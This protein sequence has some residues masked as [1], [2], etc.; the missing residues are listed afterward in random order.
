MVFSAP[1]AVV[2][3]DAEGCV[4]MLNP[5]AERLLQTSLGE[6]AGRSYAEVFGPSLADRVL[7]LFLRTVR[8]GEAIEPLLLK[9]MLPGGRG[10]EL[11]ASMGPVRD[12]TG[13]LAGLLFVADEV[14]AAPSRAQEETTLRLREALRRYLGENIAAM[15]EERPSFISVGGVRRHIS[16]LHAD[17][18]GYTTFA[19][20]REPE[21]VARQLLRYHGRA[22]EVLQR[23]GATLDRF[24]GDSVL[25]LWN[26]PQPR[27]SHVLAA[28]QGALAVQAAASQVGNDL[29]YGIGVHTGD[30]VVG[31]VGN[32][33]F[34]NYTAVGDTVNVAARLQ[35]AAGAGEVICSESVLNAAGDR[36]VARP[37]G[38]IEVKGRREPVLAHRVERLREE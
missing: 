33:H 10:V 24:I 38:A 27:D 31:N 18:R 36:L 13:A 16:V 21:E 23:E 12:D 19:E 26:A 22:V 20:G 2:V 3:L 37:L 32:E 4:T 1:S 9:A 7:R 34:L 29:A 35:A 8:G 5:H 11:R 15:V 14:Q 28:V 17:I 6:A 25:A 30:A